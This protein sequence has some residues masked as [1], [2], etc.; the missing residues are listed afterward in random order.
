MQLIPSKKR[1]I[2]WAHLKRDFERMSHSWNSEV[3][4]LGCYLRNVAT[5]I[6]ALKKA[7]LK[8]SSQSTQGHWSCSS[9]KKYHEIR[10]DDV[11]MIQ[12]ILH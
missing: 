5:E 11:W 8:R 1:E 7:L 10:A 9:S 2:C 6:F 12:K 3:K 4:I